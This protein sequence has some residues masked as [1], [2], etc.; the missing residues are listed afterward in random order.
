MAPYYLLFASPFEDDPHKVIFKDWL[1]E[2]M[3]VGQTKLRVLSAQTTNHV[4]H[5][6]VMV[7]V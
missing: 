1:I 7:D 6:M 5:A 4:R 3:R 2:E